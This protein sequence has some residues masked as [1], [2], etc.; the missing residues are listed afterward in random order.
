MYFPALLG[1]GGFD[2]KVD[3]KT[4]V[5]VIKYMFTEAEVVSD[6]NFAKELESDI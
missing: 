6:E 3:P 2:D 5:V 4:V 1:W